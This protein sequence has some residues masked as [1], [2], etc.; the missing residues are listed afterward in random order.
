MMK[1]LL[2]LITCL[3]STAVNAQTG[4]NDLLVKY[5]GKSSH[6]TSQSI[7]I[8][9]VTAIGLHR[10]GYLKIEKQI[11]DPELQL[12]LIKLANK[13]DIDTGC[14]EYLDAT[15]LMSA[16]KAPEADN[17]ELIARVYFDFDRYTLTPESR[18]ILDGITTRLLSQKEIIRIDGHTDSTGNKK[19]NALLG[20][21]RADSTSD[22]LVDKGVDK[23]QL[24][25]ISHGE[26]QPLKDNT[27]SDGRK[28][29]RRVEILL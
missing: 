1:N 17:D 28:A 20:L 29:N 23:T 16:H 3:A 13:V 8:D 9:Q 19:Y 5:C 11:H 14:M 7:S 6:N 21:R 22:Y 4:F 12:R 10:D 24:K 27:T 15:K 25:V 18:Q 26:E 2:I